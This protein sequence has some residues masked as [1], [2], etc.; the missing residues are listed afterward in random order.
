MIL[1]FIGGA[2]AYRRRDHAQVRLILNL[3]PK[4]VE[5][6]CLV[7]AD[8]VVFFVSGLIAVVSI[9]FVAASWAERTPIL[10]VPAALIAMPLPVGLR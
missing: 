5:R 6:V 8:V 10:Q 4:R 2:V 7:L 9:E 1:A 3:V